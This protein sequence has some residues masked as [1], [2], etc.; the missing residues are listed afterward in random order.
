MS[1]KVDMIGNDRL[2]GLEEFSLQKPIIRNY[3]LEIIASK[4]MLFN[5]ILA[6]KTK[7]I[8]LYLNGENLG[9]YHLEEGFSKEILELNKKKM[10]QFL[11]LKMI[12]VN[13]FQILLLMFIQNHTGQKKILKF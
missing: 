8:D 10:G 12:K 5:N 3:S 7:I 9:I 2:Y 13:F 6:S 11:V 4:V 1:F